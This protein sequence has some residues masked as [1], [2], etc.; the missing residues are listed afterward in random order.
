MDSPTGSQWDSEEGDTYENYLLDGVDNSSYL[1]SGSDDDFFLNV[2]SRKSKWDGGYKNVAF[3]SGGMLERSENDEA[4]KSQQQFD[5]G[6]DK[7]D[8][9]VE[10]DFELINRIAEIDDVEE[11]LGFENEVDSE[12][13]YYNRTKVP[14]TK[15]NGEL[16]LENMEKLYG[17]GAKMLL[18]MGYKG[19]GLGK[20]GRGI[21]APINTKVR[22]KQQGLQDQGE[23]VKENL[24]HIRLLEQKTKATLNHTHSMAWKK[25]VHSG[26]STS[27]DFDAN[28]TTPNEDL[29][30]LFEHLQIK[31][32]LFNDSL[33]ELSNTKME[34]TS[35]IAA[36]E[37]D[38][39]RF[40]ESHRNALDLYDRCGDIVDRINIICFEFDTNLS[41]GDLDTHQLSIQLENALDVIYKVLKDDNQVYD[42]LGLDDVIISL[43]QLGLSGLYSDWDVK[44]EPSKGKDILERILKKYNNNRKIRSNVSS[45][46]NETNLNT[47]KRYFLDK[48][49][50][51]DTDSGIYLYETWVDV[52]LKVD[53]QLVADLKDVLESRF[54]ELI[55]DAATCHLSHVIIHPWLFIF[56]DERIQI[57]CSKLVEA[58]KNMISEDVFKNKNRYK[59]IL[60]AWKVLLNDVMINSLNTHICAM[61]ACNISDVLINPRNQDTSILEAALDWIPVVGI[62][63]VAR[64]FCREFFPRWIQRLK[65]WVKMPQANFEEIIIWY[66]GWKQLFPVEFIKIIEVEEFFK[67]ALV[68]ME[69]GCNNSHVNSSISNSNHKKTDQSHVTSKTLLQTLSDIASDKGILM[70]PR[71]GRLHGGKQIYV[72][73]GTSILVH[74]NKIQIL[75]KNKFQDIAI[76]DLVSYAIKTG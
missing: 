15:M 24:N 35:I 43:L 44:K 11:I 50:I 18:K 9:D 37:N 17:K 7:S 32:N 60:D 70:Q 61:L 51:L 21:V 38:I 6:L 67:D 76:D 13:T 33:K 42:A 8:M 34:L 2:T 47:L 16:P 3:V 53:E 28:I 45:V 69:R 72:F 49:D 62:E 46:L 40:I 52:L 36:M 23:M 41:T 39:E 54:A 59:S 20:D 73:G 74:E 64:V 66:Q 22:N 1:Y 63:Y 19:G 27:M 56:N 48:W 4:L 12:P 31:C 58:L 14:E 29:N 57:L 25:N 71:V 5:D 65:K 26:E 30:K 75:Y 55:D 10:S 68:I